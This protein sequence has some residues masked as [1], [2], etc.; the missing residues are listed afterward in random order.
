MML[1][2]EGIPVHTHVCFCVSHNMTKP[3]DISRAAA[4]QLE[5]QSERSCKLFYFSNGARRV[6]LFQ[7]P[8]GTDGFS[9]Q[10]A[11]KDRLKLL[12]TCRWDP[13]LG[14]RCGLGSQRGEVLSP[15]KMHCRRQSEFYSWREIFPLLG[16]LGPGLLSLALN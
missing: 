4:Q 6:G 14:S 9:P 3:G 8:G 11:D 2:C 16:E 15:C 7:H 5:M 13:Q 12:A 1:R 10:R